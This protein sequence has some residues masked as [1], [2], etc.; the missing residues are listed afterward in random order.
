[1]LNLSKVSKNWKGLIH[2]SIETE[3]SR[4]QAAAKRDEQLKA[5]LIATRDTNDYYK[6][7]C[8]VAKKHGYDIPLGELADLGDEF[9]DTM[10][11]SQNGGGEHTFDVWRDYLGMFF[12]AII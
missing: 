1:M 6:N 5:E 7:F 12:D 8:D 4:L 10:M 2:M 11:R 3:L 9:C